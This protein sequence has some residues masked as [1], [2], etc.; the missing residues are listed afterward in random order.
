[1]KRTAFKYLVLLMLPMS[2]VLVFGDIPC[3]AAENSRTFSF[4]FENDLFADTDKGCTNGIKLS[5]ISPGL[6]GYA[7]S[8]RL[9]G[10]SLPLIR[11]LPFINEPGPRCNVVISIGQNIYTPEDIEAED[12]I[13][14]DRPY[15]GWTYFGIG[16][17][18]KNERRLD[19]MEIQVG[20]V[21]PASFAEQTQ[22][23]VHKWRGC[24]RSNGWGNQIKNEPGPAVI[25]ERKWR[26]Q[27]DRDIGK[28]GFDVI[29]HIGGALGNV[30]TYANAGMEA[31]PGWN[32]PRD[33]GTSLICPSGDS[34]AP[35]S[36]QYP[37]V[38]SDHG[39]GLY[40]F[41]MVEGPAVL[42]NIFLDGNTFNHSHSVDK[43][44]LRLI[45][46]QAPD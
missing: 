13:E 11:R 25:Y 23:L 22:K 45:S 29:P 24:Q 35:L 8:G 28:L 37:R 20:M 14:G 33:F 15:A 46:E 40:V 30:Y 41:G 42:H 26:F 32:I 34:N 12:L 7:E 9:P 44:I 3:E 2:I 1:M 4:Y 27:Y 18:S 10:W 38:K 19:S 21:G 39:F 16:L 31:R 36:T 43:K 5:W 6:T 17:H